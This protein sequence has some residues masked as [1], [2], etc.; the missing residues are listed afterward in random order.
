MVKKA[1]M[2]A[3][4]VNGVDRR[5]KDNGPNIDRLVAIQQANATEPLQPSAIPKEA[6]PKPH[7]LSGYDPYAEVGSNYRT[8]ITNGARSGPGYRGR[9]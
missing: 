5:P 7:Q 4:V 8:K 9:R 3:S 2:K 6:G 1:Y